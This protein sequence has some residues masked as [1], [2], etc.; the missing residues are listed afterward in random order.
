MPL[1]VYVDTGF[2]Q[3]FLWVLG[4]VAECVKERI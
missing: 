2:K 1:P 3:F 4:V